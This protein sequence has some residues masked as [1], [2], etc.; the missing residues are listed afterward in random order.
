MFYWYSIEVKQTNNR[1]CYGISATASIIEQWD[2]ISLENN[3]SV[4]TFI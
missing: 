3:T 1:E 4:L 2:E